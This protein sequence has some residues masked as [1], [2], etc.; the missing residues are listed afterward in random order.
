MAEVPADATQK[1]EH[2]TFDTPIQGELAAKLEQAIRR[3]AMGLDM[4]PNELLGQGSSNHWSGWQIEESSVKL[5]IQPVLGRICDA[6]TQGYL[7]PALKA[8][9]VKDPEKYT[10]W[11][12]ISPL[13]VRPN[14]FEDAGTL[15][16]KGLIDGDEYR[17][18]G[19][20]SDE[21]KPDNK[22]LSAQRAWEA[23]KLDPALLQQ[24]AFADLV[25]LPTSEPP[26]PEQP[27]MPPGADP[28]AAADDSIRQQLGLP[29][30]ESGGASP[31]QQGLTASGALLPAAEQAVLRALEL[32]GG[33]MLDRRNRGQFADVPRHEMHT[34]VQPSSREHAHKLL[35]GAF[36]H[37]SVMASHF[38]LGAY[39]LERLL[40]NYTVELLVRG[41]AHESGFL[42]LTL[43]AAIG[44]RA[45]ADA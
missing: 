3:L 33:R 40:E 15:Y 45:H 2:L 5:F 4:D 22:E 44:G 43:E 18:S 8:Q 27:G 25:G 10:L 26:A 30:T 39:D 34:R 41:Y 1:P 32:A 19:N 14:R 13:S 38:G 16:D 6:L 36:Q 28:A 11:Y 42:Q 35:F 21:A 7:I 37:T 20:F 17:R 9:G 31:A 12:D 29:Q 23:I 24:K